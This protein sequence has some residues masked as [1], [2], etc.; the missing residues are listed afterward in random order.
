[1]H[2]A[3][4]CL[5]T[6]PCVSCCATH[7]PARRAPI[8]LPGQRS[9][10]PSAPCE[11]RRP[12]HRHFLQSDAVSSPRRA[13]RQAKPVLRC[14][15]QCPV[16]GPAQPCA[17]SIALRLT[18]RQLDIARF[19]RH[20]VL[21]SPASER[22]ARSTRDLDDCPSASS[23]PIPHSIP[24]R[25]WDLVESG[26]MLSDNQSR[27]NRRIVEFPDVAGQPWIIY[28][29]TPRPRSFT[30]FAGNHDC[31]RWRPGNSR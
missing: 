24:H 15:A 1:M 2:I 4:A 23:H 14:Q 3:L 8:A 16:C 26:R 20:I 30:A 11:S 17:T 31:C 25:M 27:E 6:G 29:R 19:H 7:L 13:H 9:A 12:G 28:R 22:E 5:F 18:D 10:Q 21:A